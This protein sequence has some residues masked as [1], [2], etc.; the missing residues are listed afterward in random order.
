LLVI[1]LNLRH[2]AVDQSD[3]LSQVLLEAKSEVIVTVE[4]LLD[5]LSESFGLGVAVED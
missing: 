4:A 2:A 5:V 1:N 3:R